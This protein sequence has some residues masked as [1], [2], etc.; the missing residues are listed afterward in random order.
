MSALESVCFWTALVFYAVAT[1]GYI[2]SI[3]FKNERVM[4][5]LLVLMGAGVLVHSVAIVARTLAQGHF[6]WSTDYENGLMGG[7]F[8]I[9]STL[10]V[11]WRQKPLRILGAA[12]LP[13]ALL[14]MGYGVMRHPTLEP[15]SATLK[16][17][18][19]YIH[20]FF[21][22]LSFG[23][24]ALAMAA[25]ILYL[26]RERASG[27]EDAVKGYY[28]QFPPQERLDELMFKY[29]VFG[30]INNAVMIAAG[31]IW[32]KSLWGNYWSWD[33]VETWSLVSWLMYGIAIHLRI[34]MG[35]RGSR[36][37]WVAVLALSTVI[38]NFF[39]V[40]LVAKSS[41]HMFNV[42]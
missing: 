7:W 13:A 2:Y 11:S 34:T 32:A 1:G 25:G 14:I 26:L 31:A 29:L 30:F 10:Y 4:P 36:F 6:P 19:L 15:M 18:W 38:I 5:K 42:R 22:W 24:Y 28:E 41:L 27:K 37:A 16:S 3:V 20:V 33:P 40:T 12:T 17:F 23:A 9:V 21:A 39:G 8:I 35:W